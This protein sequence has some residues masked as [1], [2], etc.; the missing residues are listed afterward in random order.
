MPAA[1]PIAGVIASIAGVAQQSKAQK[2]QEAEQ[3]RAENRARNEAAKVDIAE[4][5]AADVDITG[6]DDAAIK[7]GASK[8]K[9]PKKNAGTTILPPTKGVGGL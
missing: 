8:Q 1:I 7:R 6:A 2:A 5:T 3:R 4:D 9:K